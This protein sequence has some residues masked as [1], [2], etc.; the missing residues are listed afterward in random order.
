MT[1]KWIRLIIEA[2]NATS[3]RNFHI[4]LEITI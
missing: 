3:M 2:G 4:K 1:N